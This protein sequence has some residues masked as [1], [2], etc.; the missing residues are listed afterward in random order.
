[1]FSNGRWLNIYELPFFGTEYLKSDQYVNWQTGDL[2]QKVGDKFNEFLHNGL[3][4][5]LPT[6]PIF[7]L[8]NIGQATY[9]TIKT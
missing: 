6:H 4:I 7:Q 1:M 3:N 2:S 8:S 9:G 5:N